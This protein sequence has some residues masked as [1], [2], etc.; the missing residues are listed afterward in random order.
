[1][2]WHSEVPHVLKHIR[3]AWL[4]NS[5]RLY[6]RRYLVL[7]SYKMVMFNSYVSHYQRVYI[8]WYSPDSYS[9]IS[10]DKWTYSDPAPGCH[11]IFW[12]VDII[13]L[14]IP[15]YTYITLHYSTLHYI[16]LHYNTI[17]YITYSTYI[18]MFQAFVCLL[19]PRFRSRGLTVK[20]VHTHKKQSVVYRCI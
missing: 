18:H 6:G 17:H 9:C 14:D 11:I 7:P 5:P 3:N 10:T 12:Y 2:K 1:M 15:W 16:K 13:D 4:Q 19:Y 8:A 20:T